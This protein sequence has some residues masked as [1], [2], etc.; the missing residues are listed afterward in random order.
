MFVANIKTL[1][2]ILYRMTGQHYMKYVEVK[3][4]MNLGWLIL[5]N[6][7]SVP[8]VK[9]IRRAATWEGYVYFIYLIA[10]YMEYIVVFNV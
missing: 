5:Q 6:N 4:M 9:L 3:V 7:C 8:G 2:H 1:F 10:H